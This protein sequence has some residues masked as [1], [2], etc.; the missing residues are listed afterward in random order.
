LDQQHR[1]L[2][3]DGIPPLIDEVRQ[4]VAYIFKYYFRRD[5]TVS[6]WLEERPFLFQ[7]DQLSGKIRFRSVVEHIQTNRSFNPD[8]FSLPPLQDKWLDFTFTFGKPD[9]PIATVDRSQFMK[10]NLQTPFGDSYPYKPAIDREGILIANFQYAV[11]TSILHLYNKLMDD[12]HLATSIDE[13]LWLNDLRMLVN[14]C[15][16][17]VDIT[18]HQLY[19]MAEHKGKTKGWRFEPDKLGAKHGM[20]L[21]DKLAWIGKI[22]GRPLDDAQKELKSFRI[23]KGIR[24]QFNHFD[25]PGVAYTMEDLVQWFNLIPDI[26]RLIWKIRRNLECQLS[27]TIV[28]LIFL[29]QVKFVPTQPELSR[30]PQ[31]PDVG[32]LSSITPIIKK[33]P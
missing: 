12:A 3:H 31:P 5:L 15:V 14:E 23:I 17:L 18:L 24:N 29:P 9:A 10:F 27:R 6:K 20:R 28:E 7:F 21:E 32:Y 19:Y 16:S 11:Q 4:V 33:D 25:P 22:T 26:G 8:V 13:R 30:I 2:Q 1:F